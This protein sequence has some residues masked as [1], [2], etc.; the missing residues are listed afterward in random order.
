[1]S[2]SSLS[3]FALEF[4][5]STCWLSVSAVEPESSGAMLCRRRFSLSQSATAASV[6]FSAGSWMYPAFWLAE[7]YT[8]VERVKDK[9]RSARIARRWRG[10]Q[11]NL[12]YT[13]IY[14][15]RTSRQG[16]HESRIK[17]RRGSVPESLVGVLPVFGVSAW[18]AWLGAASS[19]T[20][21]TV[22]IAQVAAM[23][24]LGSDCG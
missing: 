9:P 4:E 12:L 22:A 6:T 15:S 1:M 19:L 16:C 18:W 17:P 11:P 14:P 5:G 24:P 23:H 7:R 13:I 20:R 2:Q 8:E 10:Y 21:R 3:R